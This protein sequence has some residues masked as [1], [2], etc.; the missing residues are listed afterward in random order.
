VPPG[1]TLTMTLIDFY[2]D[3]THPADPVIQRKA[4]S[5]TGTVTVYYNFTGPA[6]TQP[7]GKV[8]QGG[9]TIVDWTNLTG[10]VNHPNDGFGILSGIPQGA[11]YLLHVRDGLQPGNAPTTSDGTVT[12]GVG[13]IVLMVGTTNMD[14]IVG[15]GATTNVV[16]GSALTE[17]NYYTATPVHA[18][19]FDEFGWHAPSAATNYGPF[20]GSLFALMRILTAGLQTLYA[21]AVPVG[22][23]V[24][25]AP[26]TNG[27]AAFTGPT[28]AQYL[29]TIAANGTAPGGIGMGSPGNYYGGDFEIILADHGEAD[30]ADTQT[31]YQQRLAAFYASMLATV[32]PFG[33]G[34]NNLYY[35]LCLPGTY[36]V[37]TQMLTIREAVIAY[38]RSVANPHVDLSGDLLDL[39]N[40]GT[41]LNTAAG[42][43]RAMRRLLQGA[44]QFLGC[45]TVG[46][47]GPQLGSFS[48]SGTTVTFSVTH[49][50]GTALQTATGGAPTGFAVNTKADFTGTTITPSSV[51]LVNSNTQIALALP[52]GTTFPVYVQYERALAPNVTNPIY[53]N[54]AYPSG[55]TGTD[56]EALGFPLQ[57]TAG[58]ITVQVVAGLTAEV[59]YN[60][61]L[62]TYS[63][64]QSH[65]MGDYTDPE[66]QFV[67]GNL[68]A[69][70]PG[71]P[72]LLTSDPAIPDFRVFFRSNK[73]G[74]AYDSVRFE[75]GHATGTYANLLNMQVTIKRS[76]TVLHGP[77]S[78]QCHFYHCGW[79]WESTPFPQRHTA[80]SLISTNKLPYYDDRGNVGMGSVHDYVGTYGPM[81]MW[82]W[83]NNFGSTG[84]SNYIGP[85]LEWQ[86]DWLIR[87]VNWN[88]VYGMC[89]EAYSLPFWFRDTDG[90]Q[91]DL[92]IHLDWQT[93]LKRGL[94]PTPAIQTSY[95]VGERQI[96]LD[97]GHGPT[98]GFVPFLVTGDP[99]ALEVTQ[100]TANW[101]ILEYSGGY[102]AT[103]TSPSTIYMQEGRYRGWALRDALYAALATPSSSPASWLLPKSYFDTLIGRFATSMLAEFSGTDAGMVNWAIQVPLPAPKTGHA[104]Q[105]SGTFATPWQVFFEGYIVCLC[106]WYGYTAFGPV[107]RKIMTTLIK[108]FDGTTPGW[109]RGQISVPYNFTMMRNA[110]IL[111]FDTVTSAWKPGD[112]KTVMVTATQVPP[113]DVICGGGDLPVV[114]TVVGF[115]PG[116]S[117]TMD[118]VNGNT[119]RETG[120]VVK[121][122]AAGTGVTV[123]A[124]PATT[125]VAWRAGDTFR[126]TVFTDWA[127]AFDYNYQIF[128]QDA[129]VQA[130]TGGVGSSYRETPDGN[131]NQNAPPYDSPLYYGQGSSFWYPSYARAAYAMAL[132]IGGA[133][134]STAE[135]A[136]LQTCFDY[137]DSNIAAHH[138]H[139]PLYLK[140]IQ[141]PTP[142]P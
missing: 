43:L 141:H 44:L 26:A 91:A 102:G 5:N 54:V 36:T 105:A 72:D 66:G 113:F 77:I 115:T 22:V 103:P 46:A 123:T 132:R 87:G 93:R 78:Y 3:P 55:T 109:Y 17:A 20:S 62:T 13:V 140:W 127:E 85:V 126:G 10:I 133:L 23:V 18:S 96:A 104:G 98:A 97:V 101:S 125:K 69:T 84:E 95:A 90:R 76:G 45:T 38:V 27:L 32:L 37:P 73:S 52:G 9:T 99:Y 142:H 57:P 108:W 71:A 21:K 120:V 50:G 128:N 56:V 11:G 106:Y 30:I 112:N 67:Q 19:L 14:R 130:G 124:R 114:Q 111:L 118:I 33:R 28:G 80:A 89:Q 79:L 65:D 134:F 138:S 107:V 88:A 48:I 7:Q 61:V 49:D 68:L 2:R 63:T 116:T 131:A 58:P 31:I 75:L 100:M 129:F 34:Q 51:T 94:L 29:Q 139:S 8:T 119:V 74:F 135:I 24:W 64:G 53:D 83:P 136:G 41:Y 42:E 60:G 25:T 122:N 12:W 70:Y 35:G 121:R 86:A 47:S 81:Y 92:S 1:N 117:Y 15:G 39:A 110:Q 59:L 82:G 16:P 137:L 40:D 4:G 6:P